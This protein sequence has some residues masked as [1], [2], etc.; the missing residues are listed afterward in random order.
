MA[1]GLREADMPAR[2]GRDRDDD[3]DAW[4][5]GVGAILLLIFLFALGHPR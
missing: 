2:L 5:F 3:E 4:M 1:P